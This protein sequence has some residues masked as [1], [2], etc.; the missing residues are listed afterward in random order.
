MAYDAHSESFLTAGIYSRADAEYA[1][2]LISAPVTD[3]ETHAWTPDGWCTVPRVDLY[4]SV[5]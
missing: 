2:Y 5:L 1:R 4:V 3:D